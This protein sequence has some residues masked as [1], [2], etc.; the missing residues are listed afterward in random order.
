MNGELYRLDVAD[1][2]FTDLGHFLPKDEYES[3][4]RVDELYGITLSLDEKTIY[5]VPRRNRS[6]EAD[7]YAY[8]IATGTV[9]LV[10]TLD[11]AIYTGSNM[12]DS[13]GNIYFAR[14]GDAESWQ[15]NARLEVVHPP[16]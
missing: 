11:P 9:A 5:G 2:A 13:R 15:G 16:R 7:L 8:E 1:E 4:E 14:F 12:R 6:P 10:G 3:G